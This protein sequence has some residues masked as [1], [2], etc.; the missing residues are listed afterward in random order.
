MPLKWYSTT[1]TDHKKFHA[2]ACV[3]ARRYGDQQAAGQ[4]QTRMRYIPV[5]GN[6]S[7]PNASF[8]LHSR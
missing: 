5:E 1:D 3:P 4:M 8:T 7:R 6:T 2:S